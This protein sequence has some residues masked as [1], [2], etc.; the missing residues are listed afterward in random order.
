[1][2]L[3]R[4]HESDDPRRDRALIVEVHERRGRESRP[5]P[6]ASVR[7][8]E[9]RR[10]PPDFPV[11]S[12]QTHDAGRTRLH[13][14]QSSI[15]TVRVNGFAHRGAVADLQL[16]AEVQDTLRVELVYHGCPIE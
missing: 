8:Y 12:T 9:Q 14:P 1:M 15:Y 4:G 2:S 5:L 10:G 13:V 6:G 11:V 3:I 7:L 16:R